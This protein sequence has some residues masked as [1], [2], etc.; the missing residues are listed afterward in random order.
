M[1]NCDFYGTIKDHEP[2]LD[3]L[4]SNA[5]CDIYELGSEPSCELRQFRSTQEVLSLFDIPYP[6]GKKRHTVHLQLYVNGTGPEFKPTRINLDPDL[7]NGHTY[8]YSANGKGLVQLHLSTLDD[9][10]LHSSHTNHFSHKGAERW[11]DGSGDLGDASSWD[12]KAITSFS[13]KLNRFI[14]K[15]K[16]AKIGG[17]V[18]LP[19]GLKSWDD[20]FLLPPFRQDTTKIERFE[21]E[22][23]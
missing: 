20:G 11:S 14:R 17:R 19:G 16:V 5:E 4:Y 2:I 23:K 22:R 3:F 8:R 7:C 18:L 10:S 6:N 15:M 21:H 13:S 9:T 1:P 12:F